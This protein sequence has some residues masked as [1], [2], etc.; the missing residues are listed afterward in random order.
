[1]QIYICIYKYICKHTH[2]HIY[3]YIHTHTHAHI[4]IHTYT[5][6]ISIK[7]ENHEEKVMVLHAKVKQNQPGR[8][9]FYKGDMD[10]HVAS[11]FN[12]FFEGCE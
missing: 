1:M 7:Q 3:T 12:G 2:I 11:I 5:H 4:H 10:N 6:R 8:F 9:R